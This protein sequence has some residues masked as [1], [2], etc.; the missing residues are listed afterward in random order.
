MTTN[1]NTTS[2]TGTV[3]YTVVL[4]CSIA[5]ATI[6]VKSC[7]DYKNSAKEQSNFINAMGDSIRYL[8][9]KDGSQT[10]TISSLVDNNDKTFEELVFKDSIIT[11]LQKLVKQYSGHLK[12]G[13][14]AVI[15]STQTSFKDTGV[16]VVST[17]DT[18][19]VDS[20]VYIYPLY[21][22]SGT[23]NWVTYNMR[24]SRDSSYLD[25]K[26][27]N[28]YSVVLGYDHKKPFVDVTNYNPYSTTTTLRSYQVAVPKQKVWGI[29]LSTG[30]SVST[31]LKIQPYIGIGINYNLFNF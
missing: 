14:A 26:V 6:A 2:H 29:G 22:H 15:A 3:I 27:T 28:K 12:A 5:I 13:S 17:H 31:G 19:K 1:N 10:A 25:F 11:S 20:L 18:L 4:V 16:T 24:M 30:L 7:N 23:N 8:K 9:S 21:I